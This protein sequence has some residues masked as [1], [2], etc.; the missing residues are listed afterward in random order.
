MRARRALAVSFASAAIVVAV[1]STAD[2]HALLSA[3]DPADGARLDA[4][5][6]TVTASFTEPPELALSQLV[7]LDASGAE[8][9]EGE[10]K[11][12]PGDP[13]SMRVAVSDL[14][15]GVYTVTW[16]VVSKVDAHLTGGAF[17]FGIRADPSAAV[18]PP[19]ELPEEP[20]ASPVEMAGRWVLF[21]GFATLLGAAWIALLAFRD[22]PRGV[23]LL[24]LVAAAVGV[25]GVIVLGVA[26]R[27]AAAVP[28]G[29]LVATS[30]GR[31]LVWRAT[32]T[33]VA[34]VAG[35]VAVVSASRPVRRGALAVAGVA[36]AALMLV[37]VL[38]GHAASPA[39]LGIAA[40]AS[41]WAH[42]AAVG[43]WIGGLA[44]LIVG[45]RGR[46]DETKAAAVRRFSLVAGV[47]LGVV[48]V[49]GVV[50]AIDEVGS[51]GALLSSGYGR[52]V[53]V[54]TALLL[55]LAALGALNRFRNVPAAA[56]SLRGLR[57]VGGAELAIAAVTLVAAA[58]LATLVPPQLVPAV[59]EPPP[60]VLASGSDFGT[61]VRARLEMDPGVPGPNTFELF[62]EDYDSGE[63]VDAA[64]VALRFDY[65]GALQVPET[66]LALEPAG[67]GEY[68]GS[69]ANV[70]LSGVWDVT[71]LVQAS[72]GSVEVPLE[73]RT[74][75]NTIVIPPKT[76]G[77]PR[78]HVVETPDGGSV[79]GYILDLGKGEYGI[80]FTFVEE[81]GREV[82]VEGLPTI[83]VSPGEG[84]RTSLA[85]LRLSKG[86]FLG[87]ADLEPGEYRF[88]GAAQG[89]D[90][91]LSG[92]FQ[93]SIEG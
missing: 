89:P 36:A 35:L 71:A 83:A 46:E 43:V 90:G 10:A 25:V 45:V 20:A 16:S 3:S 80:H 75:C 77:D 4:S 81:S 57:R 60:A 73:V 7:V 12:V 19:V 62:L 93:E 86:H 5:P 41:Q 92:C 58:A 84:E 28:L 42:F 85:P 50:L 82:P 53:L 1:P 38:S 66:T 55:G 22:P 48:A 2:A 37:H 8:V 34:L 18:P 33:A 21:L 27:R 26:Q 74:V 87:H 78:I 56:R 47:A 64:D 13:S 6:E 49:T 14:E 68:A 54:K 23:A 72:E 69:G 51:W 29:E 11:L 15:Q 44:A 9:H 88:D 59:A 30:I 79:E 39:S 61:T 67:D 32:A 40:I 70:G 31:A 91:A 24:A 52:L 65:A 17:A 76:E 63:P